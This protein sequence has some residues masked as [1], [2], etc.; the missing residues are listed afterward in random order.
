MTQEND[1]TTGEGLHYTAKS[2]REWTRRRVEG[3]GL[4]WVRSLDGQCL[5]QWEGTQAIEDADARAGAP[6]QGAIDRYA[7]AREREA[8]E[9]EKRRK[10]DARI[11]ALDE[12]IDQH[13][14]G[15]GSTSFSWKAKVA[16]VL[17]DFAE[18]RAALIAGG[19]S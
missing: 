5:G 18:A 11:A 6:P 12:E 17:R 15:L 8:L 1:S 19:V 2:G 16:A 14:D 4:H 7:A 3:M 10:H 9:E 13:L